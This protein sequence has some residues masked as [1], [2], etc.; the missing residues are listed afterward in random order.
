MGDGSAERRSSVSRGRKGALP[1]CNAV[2]SAPARRFA[3]NGAI[4]LSWG[5]RTPEPSCLSNAQQL[6]EWGRH[7]I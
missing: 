6:G 7:G 2:S 5:L 4:L 1:P 3:E